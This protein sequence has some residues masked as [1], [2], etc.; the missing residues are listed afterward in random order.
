MIYNVS[1]KQKGGL[2]DRLF[3]LSLLCDS[4]LPKDTGTGVS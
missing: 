1:N 3:C 4:A 2:M